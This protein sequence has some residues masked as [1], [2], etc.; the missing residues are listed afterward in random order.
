[1]HDAPAAAPAPTPALADAPAPA[2]RNIL[3]VHEI[4]PHFDCSGADLRLYELVRELRKQGHRVTLLAREGRQA[5]RYQPPLEK[6]GATVV[7]DDPDRLR[8][9]GQDRK[10]TWSLQALLERER[11]DIAILSHWFWS[12]ISVVEHYLNEIRQWS[13]Q[14]RI[15]VLSEDRHGERERRSFQLTGLL[16]DL[17]RGHNYEQREVEI[18]RQADLVLYVTETDHRHWRAL[19]PDLPTMHLSTIAESGT[20]GGGFGERDGLL[21]LGNFENLANRDGVRWLLGE[22]WPHVR[23]ELPGVRLYIAGSGGGGD[24]VAGHAG[25]EFLGKVDE[26]ATAFAPRRVFVSPIRFGT[27]IITKNMLSLAHGLPVVTTRVGAEG[28]QLVDGEHALIADAPR[29]FAAATVRLYRDEALWNALAR[30]G[31]DFIAARFSLAT[32]QEQIRAIVAHAAT[33]TPRVPEAPHVWSYRRVEQQHPEVLERRPTHYR[34]PLR[35]LAYWQEG[36][37]HLDAGRPEAA[38]EQFR[39]IFTTLRGR[40]PATVL[41]AQLLRDMARC[42][43]ELGAPESAQRCERELGMLAPVSPVAIPAA[44]HRSRRQRDTP[45]ISVVLPTYNREA[46][47]RLCLAAWAYQSLPATRWELIVVDDGSTDGTEAYCRSQP[48]PFASFRYLRQANGG[49]GAARRA[50][51]AAA[52]GELLL[53]CNDDTI[54]TPNLLLEHLQVHRHHP[55][56]RLAVLGDLRPSDECSRRALSLWLNWSPFVFPQRNAPAGPMAGSGHFVTCNI[57]VRRSEVLAAGSFDPDYRIG[58]DTELGARLERRKLR[59]LYHPRAEAWHDHPDFTSADLVARAR[60]QGRVWW[61]L[62]HKHPF[63]L[64]EGRGPFGWLSAADRARTQAELERQRPAVAHAMAALEAL[65][66]IDF[67]P[68]LQPDTPAGQKGHALLEQLKQAAPL[69]YWS[70]FKQSFLEAWEQSPELPA[71]EPVECQAAAELAGVGAYGAS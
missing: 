37:R 6:L 35:T 13:P 44:P 8:H 60:A 59:V 10:T 57:S 24:L 20:P 28:M 46:T 34:Q 55:S 39:H 43:R 61:A 21:F 58:E 22:V 54:A 52:R 15:L 30:Q 31:R 69:V 27:G 3:L 64:R 29:P 26:L 71:M 33:L 45:E 36:R 7:A 16:S 40:V 19:V 38:L 5:D 53:L 9:N 12:G 2:Q 23:R 41:H 63:L 47:L 67:Q 66:H 56:P 65:D 32:L 18:Y 50:G 1:M 42:Y 70:H 4:L 62:Y 17:E 48:L 51:V 25:V 68:F 11:F 49:A 14:T